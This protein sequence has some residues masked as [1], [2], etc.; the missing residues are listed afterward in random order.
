MTLLNNYLLPNERT[1]LIEALRRDA[2]SERSKAIRDPRWKAY[3]LQN[4]RLNV[5]ILE[6]FGYRLDPDALPEPEACE[7]STSRSSSS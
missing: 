2:E 5:R 7:R 6:A 1:A 3:H 4:V